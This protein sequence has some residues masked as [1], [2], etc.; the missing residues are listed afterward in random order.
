MRKLSRSAKGRGFPRGEGTPPAAASQGR[1]VAAQPPAS[2]LTASLDSHRRLALFVNTGKLPQRAAQR[3]GS[4][5]HFQKDREFPNS[6][7]KAGCWWIFVKIRLTVR[8]IKPTL[9]LLFAG[10]G[11]DY[12]VSKLYFGGK[13]YLAAGGFILHNI[14]KQSR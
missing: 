2:C 7:E 11:R 10:V 14:E 12:Y 5:F 9:Y 13:T 6:P 1:T 3:S 8:R 4:S